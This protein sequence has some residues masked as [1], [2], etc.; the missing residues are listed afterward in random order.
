[1]GYIAAAG[2]RE[3]LEQAS[4]SAAFSSMADLRSYR[5]FRLLE[6]GMPVAQARLM[7]ASIFQVTPSVAAR[8]VDGALA[9]YRVALEEGIKK[10]LREVI[11]SAKKGAK[12]DDGTTEYSIVIPPSLA[13][14]IIEIARRS[15]VAEPTP[16]TRNAWHLRQE[17]LDAL[18]T[19]TREDGSR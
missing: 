19:A 12:A 3:A 2:A 13:M 9:R 14:P 5:I 1:M 17:T 4:G 18:V 8:L 16:K 7:V 15:N 6:A 11:K 10:A